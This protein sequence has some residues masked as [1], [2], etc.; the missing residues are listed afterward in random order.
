MKSK[1]KGAKGQG[2]GKHVTAKAKAKNKAKAEKANPKKAK[3]ST[4]SGSIS[5]AGPVGVPSLRLQPP[6]LS[7]SLSNSMV[8]V[9]ASSDGAG[10]SRSSEHEVG[11]IFTVV[12]SRKSGPASKVDKHVAEVDLAKILAGDLLGDKVYQ[13]KRAMIALEKDGECS[14]LIT[15]RGHY[16][17]A[18][19]CQD[20]LE[21]QSS[22]PLE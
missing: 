16:Q 15:L 19:R 4:G 13:C 17:L 11:S 9:A 18:L 12:N 20:Q 5:E 8:T 3:Q 14:D 1:A 21:N 10:S 22:H 7:A 2:K 6:S